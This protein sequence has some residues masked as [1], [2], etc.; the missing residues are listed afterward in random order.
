[1][2]PKQVLCGDAGQCIERIALLQE[3]L[4]LDHFH[5]YMDLGGMEHREVMRSLERFATRVMPH[6]RRA[7]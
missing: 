6:F 3:E 2:Y 1:M 5:M 7:R 4:G